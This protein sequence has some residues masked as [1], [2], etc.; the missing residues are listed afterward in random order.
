MLSVCSQSLAAGFFFVFALFP[1][2]NYLVGLLLVIPLGLAMSYAFGLLTQMIPRSGGDY[3]LVSRVIHPMVGLISS[4]VG[5]VL[6]TPA[7]FALGV[8]LQLAFLRR[9]RDDERE[10][11]SLLVT[12]AIALGIE[13]L[14]SYVYQTNYRSTNTAYANRSW[15]AGRNMLNFSGIS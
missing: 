8:F 13:G 12:W 1:G 6:V 2:G 10:E 3:M 11:L 5:L 15:V 14:L 4:F 9:L 7:M